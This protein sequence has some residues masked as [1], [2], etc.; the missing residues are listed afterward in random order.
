MELGQEPPRCPTC[1][2]VVGIYEPSVIEF[3]DGRVVQASIAAAG[4]DVRAGDVIRH[5]DCQ[6]ERIGDRSGS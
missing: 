6:L 5:R 3:A 1:G 4:P 2:D